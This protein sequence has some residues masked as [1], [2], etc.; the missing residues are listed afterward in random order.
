MRIS[1]GFIAG[2]FVLAAAIFLIAKIAAMMA[3]RGL[4]G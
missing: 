3:S 2:V 1:A 4:L